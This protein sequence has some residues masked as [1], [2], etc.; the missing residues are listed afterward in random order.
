MV[1]SRVTMTAHDGSKVEDY[2]DQTGW[3]LVHRAPV[4]TYDVSAVCPWHLPDPFVP[5]QVQVL[6]GQLS[7][8]RLVLQ[9]LRFRLHVDADRDGAVD[10]TPCKDA[11]WTWGP[12]GSGAIVF[13]NN[14]DDDASGTADNS[15]NFIN[16]VADLTDIAPIEVRRHGSALD[17]PD[18]WEMTLTLSRPDAVRLFGARAAN[19]Q[20][21]AG[22]PGVGVFAKVAAGDVTFNYGGNLDVTPPVRGTDGREYPWGRIYY[23]TGQHPMS[24]PI[25]AGLAAFLDRNVVQKPFV[26]EE[27]FESGQGIARRASVAGAREQRAGGRVP[28]L[29]DAADA[30]PRS[31]SS[32]SRT[33]RSTAASATGNATSST[34]RSSGSTSPARTSWRARRMASGSRVL[35]GVAVAAVVNDPQLVPKFALA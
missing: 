18:S 35:R 5:Q 31:S 2:T 29:R 17:P 15:D 6:E 34:C 26:L 9:E 16:G 4:G 12:N 30:A 19:A 11:P 7:T 10:D 23:G 3:T 24:A 20:E 1:V 27:L 22:P 32:E 21:V 28:R 14:D 33:T 25:D 8:I 13:C